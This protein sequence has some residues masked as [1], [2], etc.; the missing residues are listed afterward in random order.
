MERK[1]KEDGPYVC[2]KLY[3]S[4]LAFDIFVIY[5]KYLGHNL[6]SATAII[7]TITLVDD[8]DFVTFNILN[9]KNYLMYL[10]LPYSIKLQFNNRNNIYQNKVYG[11]EFY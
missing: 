3:H 2:L 8:F 10:T 11:M 1:R 5:A 9:C 4:A 7:T 6:G